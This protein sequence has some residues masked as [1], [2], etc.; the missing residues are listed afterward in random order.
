MEQFVQRD[1][2]DGGRDAE[3][4]IDSLLAHQPVYSAN[5][6]ITNK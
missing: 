6:N 5:L 1:Y 2:A 3:N 4:Q